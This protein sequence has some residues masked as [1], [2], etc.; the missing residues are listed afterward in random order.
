MRLAK[1]RPIEEGKEN[2][3]TDTAQ[4]QPEAAETQPAASVDPTV[5]LLQQILEAQKKTATRLGWLVFFGLLSIA[6]GI[7]SVFNA[8]MSYR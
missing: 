6:G 1:Y 4:T 7:L 3:M 2:T 8:L 5:E